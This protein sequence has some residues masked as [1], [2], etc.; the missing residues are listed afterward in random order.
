MAIPITIRGLRANKY[1]INQY[2]INN[3]YIPAQDS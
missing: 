1:T 3:I 2:T